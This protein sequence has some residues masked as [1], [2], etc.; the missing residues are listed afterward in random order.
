MKK[1]NVPVKIILIFCVILC[2]GCANTIKKLQP[3]ANKGGYT[4]NVIKSKTQTKEVIITGTIF[5]L[6]TGKTI[7]EGVLI[8]HDCLK[9]KEITDGKFSFNLNNMKGPDF[10]LTVVAVG[11][12]T[13][14]TSVIYIYDKK[15][16]QIDFYLATDD[17]PLIECIET[18]KN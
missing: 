2:L 6:T 7:S 3:T 13:I 8:T 17:R 1:L 4:V 10:F 14:E 9:I 16:I 18:K 15:Q 11:Y 5:D 12:R